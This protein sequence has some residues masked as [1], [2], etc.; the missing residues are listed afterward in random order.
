M[1]TSIQDPTSTQSVS[2]RFV[3][4]Y[5]ALAESGAVQSQT[6]FCKAINLQLSTFR[7]IK[8]GNVNCPMRA[9]CAIVTTYNVRPLW[10]LM[11]E[12][13]MFEEQSEPPQR[14]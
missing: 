5:R 12:G 8:D 1:A 4:A 3:K 9:I 6:E 2:T 13:G 10:L 7:K 14:V 11:D